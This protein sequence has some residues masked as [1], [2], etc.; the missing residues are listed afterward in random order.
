M[1]RGLSGET[2]AN[3]FTRQSA[4]FRNDLNRSLGALVGIAQGLVCDRQLNDRE[5]VFLSDWLT[6]NESLALSWPGDVVHARIKAVL[7]DGVV[8]EKE[9]AYLLDTLHKVIGGTLDE[10]DATSHVSE[11][12]FDETPVVEFA[13]RVFCLT[14]DFV[15]APRA[16]CAE[17]IERRGG[18][19]TPGVSKKLHYLI[20]GGL[21]SPEWKHGSFGTKIE[22]AMELKREGVNLIVVHE[23]RWANALSSYST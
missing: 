2:M 6:A 10:L 13:G 17:A 1:N 22:K 12:M 18:L 3:F 4:A 14:G 16:V 20:V 15:F 21:G 5:I 7:A 23:D 9:R 19:V 11:L 8:T